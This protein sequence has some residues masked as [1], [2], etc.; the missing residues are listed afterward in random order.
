[1]YTQL[2]HFTLWIEMRESGARRCRLR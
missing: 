2:L 1:V